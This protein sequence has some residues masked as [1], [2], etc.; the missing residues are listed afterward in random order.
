MCFPI[1]QFDNSPIWCSK[2]VEL[3]LFRTFHYVLFAY[4]RFLLIFIC[5]HWSYALGS[6]EFGDKYTIIITLNISGNLFTNTSK[7]VELT[8][9]RADSFIREWWFR[10]RFN[11]LEKYSSFLAMI[12]HWHFSL[13][14]FFF[15]KSKKMQCE[16]NTTK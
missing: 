10:E 6:C 5:R 7:N 11:F 1:I 8:K 14:V 16:K 15:A 4:A 2:T 13:K 12:T 9:V 3:F